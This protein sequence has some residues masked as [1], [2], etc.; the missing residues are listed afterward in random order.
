MPIKLSSIKPGQGAVG[1][2]SNQLAVETVKETAGTTPGLPPAN[3]SVVQ[4]SQHDPRPMHPD[5]NEFQLR[6]M[7]TAECTEYGNQGVLKYIEIRKQQLNEMIFDKLGDTGTNETVDEREVAMM[8][9]QELERCAANVP[10]Y[11]QA[12]G[13]A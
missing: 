10:G 9:I 11:A 6:R 8:I 3:H 2:A 12:P 5:P 13:T 7:T 4:P 1:E